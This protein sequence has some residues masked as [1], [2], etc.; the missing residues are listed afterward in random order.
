MS[1]NAAPRPAIPPG[2]SF[3]WTELSSRARVLDPRQPG[4][5]L[6]E[7][8]E[9]GGVLLLN[10]GQPRH[11]S[12]QPGHVPV[13]GTEQA[14]VLPLDPPNVRDIGTQR[15]HARADLA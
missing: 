11:N 2:R 4:D 1:K 10:L 14:G 9:L 8:A 6:A 5:V 3:L 7:L 15:A 12:R 13:Q